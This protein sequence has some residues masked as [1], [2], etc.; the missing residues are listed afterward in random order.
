MIADLSPSNVS[1][2]YGEVLGVNRVDARDPAGHHQPR[3]PQRL[4]QD[5]LDESDDRPPRPDARPRSGSGTRAVR[6]GDAVPRW[7]ATA[8][9][10]TP[11]RAGLTGYEFV[12]PVPA[13]RDSSSRGSERRADR[14]ST[15]VG[16]T[17]AAAPQIAGYSKGMRQRIKLAQA[18]A[19]TRRF[20]ARRAAER[21]RPVGAAEAI[22]LFRTLAAEGRHVVLSSHILHEVDLLSDRIVMMTGG[23]VV[24]EGAIAGVRGEMEDERPLQILVRCAEPSRL[25]ATIFSQDHAVEVKIHDDTPWT[26]RAHP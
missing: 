12:H 4:R 21:P 15:Q 24:A 16:L 23:Y 26:V 17:E 18:I 6:S 14:P 20:S 5:D 3:G 1:K 13:S 11:F 25:A 7:S 8:R 10:T 2:F 9:S 22:A 19:T